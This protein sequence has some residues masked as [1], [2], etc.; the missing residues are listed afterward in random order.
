MSDAPPPLPLI[1]LTGPTAVGKTALS[2]D[3]CAR[4][5]GEIVCADSRQLYSEMAIGSAAPTAAEYAA[6][7]H[8]LFHI[9]SPDNPISL[10]QYQ[11]LAYATID[12][13]HARGR[14]PLLVGGTVLYLRAVIEGLRIP[15][16]PPD[17]VLRAELEAQL[18]REGRDALFAR[19][20]RIDP[21]GAAQ[22]D[23]LNPRRVMRALEIF[24]KTGRSKV[25]LEGADPPPY[26][27]LTIG[28][29]RPREVL[30]ARIDRRVEAMID[31]GLVDETRR[32]LASGYAPTLPA[33]TSLGYREIAAHLRGELT[34]NEAVARIK[35]ETHRFVRHQSTWFRRLPNI[36]WFA[37]HSETDEALTHDL[38]TERI[39]AFLLDSALQP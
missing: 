26:R 36:D 25:D 17:P 12:A 8:H 13:I 2:L 19:L 38:V 29:T 3:I 39:S 23:G 5:G 16:V 24:L 37:L 22:V 15:E 28:L 21:K 27:I 33:M 7:P 9:R 31:A 11:R 30:Y 14:L 34:L 35:T 6:A 32:L 4:F 20:Q 10:A 1:A 18:A